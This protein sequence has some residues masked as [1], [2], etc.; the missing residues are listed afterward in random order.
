MKRGGFIS[1]KQLKY[2]RFDFKNSCNLRKLYFLPKIHKRLSNIPG[3]PVISDCGTPTEKASEF[4]DHLKPMRKGLSYI[5]NLGDFINKIWRMGSIPDNA[6]LVTA[7]FTALYPSIPHDV[8][9][10]AL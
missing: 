4:S 3:R 7:E 1:E 6:I 9:L 2:F 5:K 8:G 10:K